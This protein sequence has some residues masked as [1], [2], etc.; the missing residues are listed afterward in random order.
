MDNVQTTIEKV[1]EILQ[2]GPTQSFQKDVAQ[3]TGLNAY[4]LEP[5]AK[6]LQPVYSPLRNMIPRV[7]NTRGGTAVNWKVIAGLD[8]ARL[9]PFTA[10]GTKAG[11]VSV[12]SADKSAAFKTI[13]KGDNVSFQAQWAG[14]S[15][16]DNKAEAVQRLLATVMQLEERAICFGRTTALGSVTTPTVANAASGGT[17]GA[18][19]YNV[20]ARPLTMRGTGSLTSPGRGKKSSAGSTTT[21]GSTS[22]ISAT[23]PWVEG[24][25]AYE[26]YVGTA[27]SE[28]LEAITEINSVKLTA[29]AGTGSAASG[30][31]DNADDSNAF[32]G[33]IAQL[34]ATNGANI[35]TLATGTAGAGTKLSLTHIDDMFQ[36]LWDASRV[37]PDVLVLN[38]REHRDINTLAQASTTA[39]QVFLQAPDQRADLTAGIAY[40]FYVNKTTG[41]KVPLLLH[42]FWPVGVIAALQI[43]LPFAIP[44]MSACIEIETRQDYLQLDYPQTAPKFEFEVLVDEA[45]K[46]IFPGACGVIRN[47]ASQAVGA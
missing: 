36:N 10:E 42:P 21:S 6:V 27:G 16:I 4:N 18:A 26:W 28:K 40:G 5:A 41:R 38:S 13:S 19:T 46:V 17:I 20:I 12:S 22:T 47:I 35:N 44:G 23:V 29:L 30:V 34:T 8:I 9:D 24:A 32:D 3:S 14:R 2:A 11:T 31:T 15:F 43:K 7:G 1:T 37:D 45:L 39:T 33:I 25:V